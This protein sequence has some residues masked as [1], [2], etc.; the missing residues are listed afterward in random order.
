MHINHTY[1]ALEASGTCRAE[2]ETRMPWEKS[3][4][5]HTYIHTYRHICDTYI[6]TSFLKQVALVG[7][8]GKHERHWKRVHS[9]IHTYIHTCIYVIHT[10]IPRS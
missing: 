6:H 8:R 10:Y 2:R 5:I 4:Y 1:L 7:L 9:Y 3:T